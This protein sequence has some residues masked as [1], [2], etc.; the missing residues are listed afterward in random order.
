MYV[1]ECM[2]E[3]EPAWQVRSRETGRDIMGS[4]SKKDSLVTVGLS[5]SECFKQ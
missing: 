2:R 1:S 5:W 4:C 3:G